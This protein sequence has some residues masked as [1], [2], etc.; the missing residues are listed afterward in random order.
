[1]PSDAAIVL[2]TQD[3]R[4][5]DHAALTAATNGYEHVVPLFVLDETLLRE[6]GTPNRI[7]FLLD[8]LRGLR[9]S[10][11]ELG[12]DLVVRRGDTVA[13]VA[14][15]ASATG[16]K[17]LF[18][19]DAVSLYAQQRLRRLRELLDV[20]VANTVTAVPPGELAPEG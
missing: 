8:S 4:V 17:T 15:I 14:R 18:V 6:A 16:A 5:H 2:F 3:L 7:S 13:E 10:L 12:G 19:G 11:R 20:R 1:M 9:R